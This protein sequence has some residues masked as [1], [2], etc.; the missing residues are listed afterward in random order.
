MTSPRP[1]PALRNYLVELA[2]LR[3]LTPDQ[4]AKEFDDVVPLWVPLKVVPGV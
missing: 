4:L 1:H 3:A 2:R